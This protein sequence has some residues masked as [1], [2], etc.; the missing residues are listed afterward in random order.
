MKNA[1]IQAEATV[2]VAGAS[3]P[4]WRKGGPVKVRYSPWM[5]NSS[6]IGVLKY[7]IWSRSRAVVYDFPDPVL[8]TINA[9]R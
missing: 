7:E 8:P 1:C 5:S 4:K 2:D 3:D 6:R 9:W